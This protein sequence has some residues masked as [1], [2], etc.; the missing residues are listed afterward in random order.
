M[1]RQL[2]SKLVEWKESHRRKPLILNGARQVGK[3]WLLKEF[4]RK[5]FDNVAYVNFDG[6]SA[7]AALFG[8]GFDLRR[9]VMGIE[10]ETGEEIIPQST[11]LIFDE[12]QECP[13]ALTSLKY[14]RENLPELHVAAAGSLLGLTIHEGTGFP[15]GN[16]TVFNLY[17]LNFEEFLVAASKKSLAALLREGDGVAVSSFATQ[18]IPLLRDYYYVGGMPAA[19]LAFTEEGYAAA[20]E[21]QEQILLA[22][23][24]DMSKHIEARDVERILAV[25]G[26]IPRHLGKENKKFVFGQIGEGAR[27]RDYRGAIT[28]LAQAGLVTVVRRVSKPGMPLSA[29]ADDAAFKLFA[30]DVGLL[31]AM[32]NLDRRAVVDGNRIFT[33]FKGS[34]TEQYVCQQLVAMQ[35]SD[36]FYW[37]S[38]N[39]ASEIDF[40]VQDNRGTFP[41]EV[42]SEE[43]LKSKSLR[44]FSER[45]EG[46]SPLRFSMS[47]FRIEPWM[48]N[49]PLYA[50]MNQGLWTDQRA[51]EDR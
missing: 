28:W 19:V 34:L 14:F 24:L 39:G 9:L 23:R 1:E 43:N 36:P 48:R 30:L 21:E 41:I 46:M 2:M 49:I 29:Y 3:T 4:G 26:S 35:R 17:P 5:Y 18:A 7:M 32:S 15:V 50:I 10:A 45:Y 47:P 27:A 8:G 6:N 40:L 25:W 37:T 42:K 51:D 16:A 20:R 44:A 31:G 33:E 22:Y 12:I 11:L 38:S 13:K